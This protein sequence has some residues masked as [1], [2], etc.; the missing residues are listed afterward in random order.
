M[1]NDGAV[2]GDDGIRRCPWGNSP[3]EYRHYHDEEWGRPVG[4]EDRIYEK[5]CLEGFQAGLSWLTILRKREGFRKA[6][7]G[8]DPDVVA[9]FGEADVERLLADAS[10]VRH[11]A[12]IEAAINNARAVVG[13]RTQGGFLARLLWAYEPPRRRAPATVADIPASTPQSKDLSA[14]LRRFGFR[15]LGPTTVYASMQSLGVVND[16]LAT[17]H[18]RATVEAERSAFPRPT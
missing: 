11:R 18:V 16:H 4:E 13:L 2:A 3:L 10:I 14:Q 5:L 8:F 9:G 17:C 15:F 7:A 6:F 12:K 1:V